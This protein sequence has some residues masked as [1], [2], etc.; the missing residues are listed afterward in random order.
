MTPDELFRVSPTIVELE[1]RIAKL[2]AVVADLEEMI[3]AIRK[4]V[5]EPG[6]GT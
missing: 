3:K 6:A 2:E 5:E 4:E 1:G